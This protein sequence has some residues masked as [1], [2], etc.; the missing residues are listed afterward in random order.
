MESTS[1]TNK[2]TVCSC[3]QFSSN[4]W[5]PQLCS[6]CSHRHILPVPVTTQSQQST[7]DSRRFLFPLCTCELN[8]LSSSPQPIAS[9]P[10]SRRSSVILTTQALEALQKSQPS[11]K[12]MAPRSSSVPL[13]NKRNS[14]RIPKIVLHD[15]P[16][17]EML[18]EKMEIVKESKEERR[19]HELHPSL[20]LT[21]II[22]QNA[23]VA[24]TQNQS[25]TFT[26]EVT[27]KLDLYKVNILNSFEA[28]KKE[29]I[30]LDKKEGAN[31]LQEENG[32]LIA[33]LKQVNE[34]AIQYNERNS[35]LLREVSE[36]S[37]RNDAANLELLEIKNQ[38]MQLQLQKQENAQRIAF[39]EAELKAG[40]IMSPKFLC[41]SQG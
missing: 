16:P 30:E 10:L 38:N 27:E 26:K 3:L 12:P 2:C 6:T 1:L 23:T 25:E 41:S 8:F 17:N 18:S 7:S 19:N 32:K 20:S 4:K 15:K 39:L 34:M 21:D 29:L 37:Q 13:E 24:A 40:K 28:M 11:S 31:S 35:A 9:K 36:L 33:Q 14:V 5:K 22:I